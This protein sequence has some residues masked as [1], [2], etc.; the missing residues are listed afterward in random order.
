MKTAID[1]V[2]PLLKIQSLKGMAGGGASLPV[3]VPLKL[4]QRRRA[5]V[6]WILDA[7]TKKTDR[8]SGKFQFAQ[9]VAE[10]IVS[11]V[12]GRSAAWEKR[13]MLHKL[14]TSNRA[15]LSIMERKRR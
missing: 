13:Q 1:S 10:E 6:N 4:R 11:V 3:P 5:A 9:K 2:A 15:N 14:A 8:G 7:A 12:E